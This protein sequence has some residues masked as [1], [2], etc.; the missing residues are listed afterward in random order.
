MDNNIKND[1]PFSQLSYETEDVFQKDEPEFIENPF[2]GCNDIISTVKVMIDKY[3]TI[4]DKMEQLQTLV[5]Y[6]I[7]Q[8]SEFM[9]N[10][11][12]E[13][14]I[15]TNNQNNGQKALIT[16]D[17]FID[18]AENMS[19]ATNEQMSCF[20][21]SLMAMKKVRLLAFENTKEFVT[22]YHPQ[23][24]LIECNRN[25]SKQ[26]P[27]LSSPKNPSNTLNTKEVSIT[28]L[29]KNK[30]MNNKS[31][32]SKSWKDVCRDA[33]DSSVVISRVLSDDAYSKQLPKHINHHQERKSTNDSKFI[34]VSSHKHSKSNLNNSS[35][36]IFD[37][38]T[39]RKE[40]KGVLGDTGLMNT[41]IRY[42]DTGNGPIKVMVVEDISKTIPNTIQ[43]SDVHGV[44]I[45][46]I[47]GEVFTAGPGRFIVPDRRFNQDNHKTVRC[48]F[49]G[50]CT[51][52]NCRWYHDPM[53]KGGD[54]IRNFSVRMART[55]IDNIKDDNDITN[56][57]QLNDYNFFRD[58]VQ[59]GSI[60][61]IKAAQI[62]EHYS[63]NG[64]FVTNGKDKHRTY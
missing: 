2:E 30:S 59:L 32:I 19:R 61:L 34:T 58:I 36:N 38:K 7:S 51:H 55:I 46:N 43:Y 3:D 27:K 47:G 16:I 28:E 37:H 17:P 40:N 13:A 15:M 18:I 20:N 39:H 21:N 54:F 33:T 25:I 4:S 26:L 48:K 6:A 9:K 62:H 63:K 64:G 14:K 60:I 29:S 11:A 45:V 22:R 49:Q 12:E 24:Q 8:T 5:I 10:S 53:M 52:S 56:N 41:N 23:G 50:E 31:F 44:F 57:P 35:S 1:N 42:V